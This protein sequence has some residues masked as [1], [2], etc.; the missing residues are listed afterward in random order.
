MNLKDEDVKKNAVGQMMS[1][2]LWIPNL[3]FENAVKDVIVEPDKYAALTINM[4]SNGTKFL[5][6]KLQEEKRFEGQTNDL[7]YFRF[8]FL[9]FICDFDL[10]KYPFDQQTIK[11]TVKNFV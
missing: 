11:L 6:E 3:S 1:Q 7:V 4:K 2:Q 10:H 5:S 8:Y 9:E